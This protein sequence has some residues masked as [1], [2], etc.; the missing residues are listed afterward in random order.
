MSIVLVTGGAGGI[1]SAI[2]KAFAAKGNNVIVHYKS[3]KKRL[4]SWLNALR[5]SLIFM[6]IP[7]M[8]TYPTARL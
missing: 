6:H 8:L 2:C 4:R 3:K 7:C 5:P 1:G